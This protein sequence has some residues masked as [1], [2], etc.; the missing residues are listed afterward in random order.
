MRTLSRGV[1][2]V[3]LGILLTLS[4][5]ACGGEEKVTVVKVTGNEFAFQV[6]QTVKAGLV[7]F[8]FQNTGQ[9][10]HHMQLLKLAEGKT[11][12]DL[13]QAFA[14][15]DV[16]AALQMVTFVGGVASVG[17]GASGNSTHVLA[18][19]KYALVCFVPDPS[20]GV[21]HFAKGM[22]AAI[23]VTGEAED[24]KLP[25]ADTTV[26]MVDFAYVMRPEL[27]SGK[28]T[29]RIIND[30]QQ[31]HELGLVKLAEGKGVQDVLAFFSGQ[32]PPGPPPFEEAGG[33]QASSPGVEGN[34]EVD[35]R[36]GTYL[37][38][39]LV[40]DLRVGIEGPPHAALGMVSQFTVK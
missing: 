21:P 14:T 18:P 5:S 35:L 39:C 30:G 17:P 20:D 34:V 4:L 9:Q 7:R 2:L 26:R 12:D 27:S 36:P 25:K 23:E 29:L 24:V 19:G 38:I 13:G 37:A 22:I 33:W 40:P 15:G 8:E 32:A 10:S 31:P 3:F 6:P 16:G 1:A 28:N 11:F